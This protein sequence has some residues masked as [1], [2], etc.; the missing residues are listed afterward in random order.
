MEAAIAWAGI[1]AGA[2]LMAWGL[3]RWRAYRDE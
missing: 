1:F 3:N 2:I